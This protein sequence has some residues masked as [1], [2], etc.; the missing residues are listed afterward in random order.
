MLSE[1]AAAVRGPRNTPEPAIGCGDWHASTA[2]L[3]SGVEVSEHHWPAECS[4]TLFEL[5]SFE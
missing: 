4:E 5:L 3:L 2:E 1:P